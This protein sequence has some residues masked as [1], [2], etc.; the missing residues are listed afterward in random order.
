[1]TFLWAFV[2]VHAISYVGSSMLGVA[3]NFT[4]A[5]TLGIGAFILI[6]IAGIVSSVETPSEQ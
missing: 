3:Y 5:S 1:M 6:Y 2:L 4:T